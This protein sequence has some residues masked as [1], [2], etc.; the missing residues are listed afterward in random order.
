VLGL[1][2][3]LPQKLHDGLTAAGVPDAVAA[4]ASAAP[5]VSSVFAAFLGYDPVRTVL[6]PQA[7]GS[8]PAD[9]RARVETKSFF[10]DAIGPAFMK[11]IVVVFALAAAVCFVSAV[12]S[13]LRGGRFVADELDPERA[14]LEEPDAPGLLGDVLDESA[15]GA[16]A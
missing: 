6:G 1:A 13:W 7:V 4:H 3:S 14:P 5:P 12:A 15:V 9:V 16:R 11:G 10:P 8:L 2:G